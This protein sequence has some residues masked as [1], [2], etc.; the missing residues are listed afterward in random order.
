V[1]L[2]N[3]GA[4]AESIKTGLCLRLAEVGLFGLNV[5]DRSKTYRLGNLVLYGNQEGNCSQ[6][7]RDRCFFISMGSGLVM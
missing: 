3:K 6:C 5:Q 4:K 7:L 1:L 2:E